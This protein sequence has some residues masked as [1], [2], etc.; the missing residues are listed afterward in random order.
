MARIVVALGGNALVR[1]GQPP[2]WEEA[3]RQVR[4]TVG[5][6]AELV[7]DGHEL[8]VTHGNGPQV[9]ALLRQNE[10]AE[11]EVPPRPMHVLVAETQGQ[12]GFLISE[13]LMAALATR[14]LPRTVATVISRVEVA[15]RDPAFRKPTKPVGRYYT[16]SEARLLRKRESWELAYDGARGGWR[17]LVPSPKP[18]AWLEEGAVKRI[19]ASRG[20]EAPILIVGGGGGVPVVSRGRGIYEGVDAVVDKDRTAALIASRL[21]ADRLAIVTD[22]PA[23]AVGFR[24]P[25]ERWLGEVRLDE[26]RSHLARGEFADGSMAPKVEAAIAFVSSGG[27]GAVICHIPNL[28]RALEGGAGTRLVPD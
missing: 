6:L 10:L 9:G 21:G 12:V 3:V 13:E 26:L 4:A 28:S 5:P 8:I 7:A 23:V 18:V 22:V 19:L 1:P 20:E 25:W 27:K 14:R 24:K 2:T 17:R 11:R 16:D 15:R